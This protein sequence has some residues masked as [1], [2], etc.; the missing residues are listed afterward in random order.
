MQS[1]LNFQ[2][3]LVYICNMQDAY[4]PKPSITKQRMVEF[5][6]K[7]VTI[8]LRLTTFKFKNFHRPKNKPEYA[9]L[10]NTF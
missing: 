1:H 9:N 7:I 2:L 4:N 8:I 6:I 10:F 3:V 5:C